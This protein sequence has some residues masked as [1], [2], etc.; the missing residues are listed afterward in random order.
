[1]KL[2]KDWNKFAE[3]AKSLNSEKLYKR[4]KNKVSHSSMND[5]VY[6]IWSYANYFY[7]GR[8][9]PKDIPFPRDIV[10]T[11]KYRLQ[12]QETKLKLGILPWELDPFSIFV[13]HYG[14]ESTDKTMLTGNRFVDTINYIKAL[15]DKSAEDEAADLNSSI[16][17]L[18]H[19]QF[20]L[21]VYNSLDIISRYYKLYSNKEL[22]SLLEK[23]FGGKYRFERILIIGLSLTGYFLSKY[24]FKTISIQEKI[25]D[26]EQEDFDL[27]L[28]MYSSS[29][30]EMLQKLNI[31][32]RYTKNFAYLAS[33][34]IAYP[35]LKYE[36][37]TYCPIPQYLL[38]RITI[39]LRY[40]LLKEEVGE[41][42]SA[43][44]FAFE[45]Y[46]R[47]LTESN[48]ESLSFVFPDEDYYV[49][50]KRKDKIDAII[51]DTS[52]II[53][54][55]CKSG[56]ISSLSS[57]TEKLGYKDTAKKIAE[58][59]I[60]AYRTLVDYKANKYPHCKYNKNK[61]KFLYLLTLNEVFLIPDFGDTSMLKLI[62]NIIW[63][64]IPKEITEEFPWYLCSSRVYEQL[65]QLLEPADYQISNFMKD[66]G[67][68]I[69]PGVISTPMK[70]YRP[71]S[72]MV[73][74]RQDVISQVINIYRG[75]EN[76][77]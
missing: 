12:S 50:K 72:Q 30:E 63:E 48:S 11:R 69:T 35:L 27:F 6:L 64:E 19:Q 13:L 44:G 77:I 39:G 55:E 36:D 75:R 31:P 42:N 67:T 4:I 32:N 70:I 24:S 40:D 16:W 1:M 57:R 46:I 41:I 49:G 73:G 18:Q 10:P 22:R 21:Q 14:G 68:T 71:V 20:P 66:E 43:F 62:N 65:L 61:K 74:L 9:I 76:P 8:S 47:E 5:L 3:E 37:H 25:E 2:C 29:A 58:D 53:F 45:N 54:I 51:E 7:F 33:P 59:I 34:L 60:Q 28:S 52:G 26:L 38:E 17:R 56:Y 23:H 15:T